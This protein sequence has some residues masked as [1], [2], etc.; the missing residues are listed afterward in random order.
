MNKVFTKEVKIACVAVVALVALFFGLNFLKGVSLFNDTNMYQMSFANLKGLSTSTPVYADGYKVGS[1]KAIHYDYKT[2]GNAIV[3]VALD[4]Q[5]RVPAG[6]KATIESDL[7]G[8]IKV[9]ILMA[10][11]PRERLEVGGMIPGVEEASAMAGLASMVPDVQ[12]ML[13]KLDSIMMNLN[14][15]LGDPAIIAMLHNAEKVSGDLTTTS[16]QLNTLMT[17]L[18]QNVPGMMQKADVTLDNTQKL[19]G[20][21]AA[22][23][24]NATMA[25]V[26]KTL[27]NVEVMTATLGQTTNTLNTAMNSKEGTLGLML[28]DPGLY[29]NLN[30]TVRDADSLMVDLKAHPKRYVHFSLF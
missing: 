16:Q 30:R 17:S 28:H 8:N 15:I 29:N 19:T 21:L 23:D 25:K 14:R 11:N 7:M 2:N 20:N 4:P 18:N 1:V 12:A 26:N 22:V 27:E 10:N 24:V 5:L 6:S 13:P 9:T 3:D